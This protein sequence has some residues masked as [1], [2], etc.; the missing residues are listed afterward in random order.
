MTK[1]RFLFLFQGP[2]KSIWKSSWQLEETTSLL[3]CQHI[4]GEI[5]GLSQISRGGLFHEVTQV[6]QYSQLWS[7]ISLTHHC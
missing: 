7:L 1:L 4:K 3:P 6:F 2:I 5:Q